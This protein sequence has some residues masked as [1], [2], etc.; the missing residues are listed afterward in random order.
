MMIRKNNLRIFLFDLP[1]D[2]KLIV[3]LFIDAL[4]CIFT[5]WLSFYLRL[6]SFTFT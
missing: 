5:V 1:R 2:I 6:E 3:S 4:L